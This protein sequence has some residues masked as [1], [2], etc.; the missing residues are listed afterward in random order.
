MCFTDLQISRHPI[1]LDTNRHLAKKARKQ[2]WSAPWP[3]QPS[4]LFVYPPEQMLAALWSL[5]RVSENYMILFFLHNITSAAGSTFTSQFHTLPSFPQ[6]YMFHFE[7]AFTSGAVATPRFV[8]LRLLTGF[9][10]AI[11][12]RIGDNTAQFAM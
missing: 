7:R 6:E 12:Y 2:G 3:D 9:L 5:F 10:S 1:P 11:W 4:D 8:T